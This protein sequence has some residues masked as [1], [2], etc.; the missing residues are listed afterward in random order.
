M[1]RIA[2]FLVIKCMYCR[3]WNFL[4]L[5]IVAFFLCTI[6]PPNYPIDGDAARG[7]GGEGGAAE[8]PHFRL[9]F[10]IVRWGWGCINYTKQC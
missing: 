7:G 4:F 5:S 3:S 10:G 9:A 2:Y 6:L 8:P 1:Y